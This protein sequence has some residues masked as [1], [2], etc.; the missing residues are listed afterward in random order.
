MADTH[1]KADAN[2]DGPG[3]PS[4]FGVVQERVRNIEIR[5]GEISEALKETNKT[6]REASAAMGQFGKPQYSLWIGFLTIFLTVLG[7]G[8]F[9]VIDPLHRDIS[10]LEITS[11]S[12]EVNIER[13]NE[14]DKHFLRLEHELEGRAL[15]DDLNRL[16]IEVDKRFMKK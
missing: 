10:H 11:V 6:I 5:L 16:I 9:I 2:V 12:R 7:A 3:S 13:T 1:D 8:W 15:K 4:N 14:V